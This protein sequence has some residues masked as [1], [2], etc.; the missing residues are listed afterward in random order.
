MKYE[1]SVLWSPRFTPW[2]FKYW[3][4]FPGTLLL[5]DS[6]ICHFTDSLHPLHRSTKE[7]ALL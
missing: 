7:N 2:H 1:D 3:F 6:R 4:A 5:L